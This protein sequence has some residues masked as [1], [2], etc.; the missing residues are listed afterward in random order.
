MAA[1]SL[2]V[3]TVRRLSRSRPRALVRE[4]C[5]IG[6]VSAKEARS[7]GYL[8]RTLVQTTFPHRDPKTTEYSRSNGIVTLT[9]TSP[10]HIGVPYGSIPRLLVAWLC[11]EIVRTRSREIYLGRNLSE[12]LKK[13]RVYRNGRD[14]ARVSDQ[15]R[16][17]FGSTIHIE[18]RGKPDDF[19]KIDIASSRRSLW[20]PGPLA[21]ERAWH[22]ELVT[23]P[24][25]YDN[26][27]RA[28][29]PVD[30]R[31][32]Y[33]LSQSP[34]AMDIYAWLVHRLFLLRLAGAPQILIPWAALQLQFGAG[35]AGTPEGLRAFK[36]YF[37]RRMKEV[38]LF[39]PEARKGVRDAAEGLVLRPVDLHIAPA[40]AESSADFR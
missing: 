21:G 8:S 39:Y 35:Y 17:L 22:S 1:R 38:L 16:R 34:F 14:I 11:T 23:N 29:V 24:D 15:A 40:G 37:I 2:D 26:V 31:V 30:L 20:A 4:A 3:R 33:E 28:P 9:I 25:F 10:S 13:I 7:L 36:W 27:R 19:E 5:A 32:L 12:F 18:E 6:E